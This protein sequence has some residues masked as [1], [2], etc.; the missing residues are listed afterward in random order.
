MMIFGFEL[1]LWAV[2]GGGIIVVLIAW[3]II[4]FAIKALFALIVFFGLLFGLDLLGFFSW[5]QAFI[6]SF[7]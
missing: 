1:P 2:F 6:S 7:F 5:I 4:K 3:K